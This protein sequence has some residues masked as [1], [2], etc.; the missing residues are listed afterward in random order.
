MY[1]IGRIIR[2]PVPWHDDFQYTKEVQEAQLF[3]T[4]IVLLE[5]QNLWYDK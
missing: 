3:I 1:T 4:N 5:L 2:A